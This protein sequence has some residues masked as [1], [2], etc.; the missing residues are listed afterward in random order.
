MRMKPYPVD[1]AS[2]KSAKVCIRLAMFI[3]AK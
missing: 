1:T 2:F 3:F